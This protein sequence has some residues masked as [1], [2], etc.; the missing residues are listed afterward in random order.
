[1][2]VPSCVVPNHVVVLHIRV[3]CI[4]IPT[5]DL[6]S[7]DVRTN[8]LMLCFCVMYIIALCLVFVCKLLS[9]V[10]CC[11]YKRTSSLP[12]SVLDIVLIRLLDVFLT[13]WQD[14]SQVSCVNE[15]SCDVCL[16][17]ST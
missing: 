6:F 2:Y 3:S 13:C 7:D 9:F 8:F 10:L 14:S 17:L 5:L 11:H 16:T 1:M 4:S 12:V 15:C